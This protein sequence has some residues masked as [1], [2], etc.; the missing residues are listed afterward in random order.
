NKTVECDAVNAARAANGVRDQYWTE[1]DVNALCTLQCS[2]ALNE[3]YSSVESSCAED[4]I[5][6]SDKE[7]APKLI[8]QKY[9]AGYNAVCLQDSLRNWCIL[10]SQKWYQNDIPKPKEGG[11]LEAEDVVSMFSQDQKKLIS[12]TADDD[13]V[14]SLDRQFQ[15]IVERCAADSPI[16]KRRSHVS[17]KQK[18]D[19]LIMARKPSRIEPR[20]SPGTY[21]DLPE[22]IPI[23]QGTSEKGCAKYY[24]IQEGDT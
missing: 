20:D 17:L 18:Q 8:P 15:K 11:V 23:L 13:H 24:V 9:I 1:N 12:P 2:T 21:L 5:V 14:A 10:E 6:I 3:W 22:N 4:T 16:I 19:P 7:I